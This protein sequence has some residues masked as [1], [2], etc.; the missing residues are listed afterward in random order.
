METLSL[1]W[2]KIVQIVSMFNF[3]TDLFDILIVAFLIYTIFSMSHSRTA[4]QIIKA[5]IGLLVLAYFSNLLGLNTLNYI[6][7][8]A[9]EVGIVALVVVF[10]PELRRLLERIDGNTLGGLIMPKQESSETEKTIDAVVAACR[11]MSRQKIGALIVFERQSPLSEYFRTGTVVDA[12]VSSELLKNIFFP[13]AALHDGAVVI[14]NDRIAAAGCVLPLTEDPNLSRD[15]GTR[16]R[17]AIG[18]TERS[19]AVV[20]VVSEETGVI[21]CMLPGV[22]KRYLTPEN[23]AKLLESELVTPVQDSRVNQIRRM[24]A[25]K[26]SSRSNGGGHDEE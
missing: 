10:Q 5:V 22:R 24:I 2:S 18:M 6:V 13:K 8:K 9:L 21:S 12:A 15:L 25:E 26:L 17:A 20:V 4:S 7:D 14:R 19:D 3:P 16:H 1:L 11:G 23:L